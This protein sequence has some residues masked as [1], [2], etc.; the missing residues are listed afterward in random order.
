MN[1]LHRI[2][3]VACALMVIG[4][5][6][7]SSYTGPISTTAGSTSA[8]V[9]DS[10]KITPDEKVTSPNTAS[11][12]MVDSV[13]S[14]NVVF[15]VP[16]LT[17]GST[18]GTFTPTPQSVALQFGKNTKAYAQT[19][20]LALQ[21]DL[22]YIVQSASVL[23]SITAEA[24]TV[25]SSWGLTPVNSDQQK[26]FNDVV[27]KINQVGTSATQIEGYLTTLSANGKA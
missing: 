24:N 26:T 15:N 6:A 5:V 25:G 7:C 11:G 14:T 4:L 2:M 13:S 3:S 21:T 16:A 1:L 27:A 18:T 22:P 20:A 10:S 9:A 19:L 23:S 17:T 12:T 8:T